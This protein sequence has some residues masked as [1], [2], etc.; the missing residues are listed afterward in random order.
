MIPYDK[1]RDHYE[2]LTPLILERSEIRPANWVSPYTNEID[3]I[4][5]FTPIEY[6]AWQAIRGNGKCPL[7]PQYPVSKYFLDFGNPY[8]KIGV[9][10]DGAEFY[11]DKEKDNNRDY[12]LYLLGWKIYRISG[13][14]CW[15]RPS[16]EFYD[17]QY[18]P[19]EDKYNILS[20]YYSN[21]I[22][23]L[24]NA[25]SIVHCKNRWYYNDEY[26][27]EKGLAHQ[28]VNN[29]MSKPVKNWTNTNKPI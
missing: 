10:C 17:L 3:W 27:N 20:D 8:L 1:I 19:E 24:I 16:N 14:D 22:E 21:T 12:Q 13:A 18:M 26:V 4:K 25:L 5:I 2:Y 6:D 11:L 29:R 23:G 15:R 28:C 9:E 7:Y